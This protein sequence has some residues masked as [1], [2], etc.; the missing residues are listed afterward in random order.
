M[1]KYHQGLLESDESDDTFG[2][3]LILNRREWLRAIGG[4]PG[5]EAG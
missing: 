3:E 4:G 1:R 2:R 5:G